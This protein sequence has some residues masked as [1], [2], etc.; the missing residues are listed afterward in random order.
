MKKKKTLFIEGTKDRS[1]GNLRQGFHK[2]LKSE[3][4]GI[5]PKIIMGNG[6]SQAITKFKKSNLSDFS[7]L[8]IDLDANEVEKEKSLN[9]SGLK[10]EEDFV[11]FMIQ[12]MEAWF[13]SQPEILDKFYDSKLKLPNKNPKE[14]QN[15]ASLL[16]QITKGTKKGKY[17]KVK[18]GTALLELLDTGLLKT[19]FQEFNNMISKISKN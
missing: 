19:S 13:I 15:P 16:E 17:H 9:E 8:L 18:H 5:M 3:L 12:E 10:K 14:I 4:K 7:Y 6:K 11:F 2:L 1:N